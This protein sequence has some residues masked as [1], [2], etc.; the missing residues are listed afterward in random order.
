MFWFLSSNVTE[1]R[2]TT[3]FKI[4]IAF[5][6]DASSSM[7]G[8]IH[9]AQGQIWGLSESLQQ[10]HKRNRTVEVE[11]AVISYGNYYEN[12][13]DFAILHSGFSSQIDSLAEALL[14]IETYGGE[15][16]CGAVIQYALDVLK[17]SD[18]KE[19]LKIIFIAGN[20]SFDQ[21]HVAYQQSIENAKGKDVVVNTLFCGAP[22]LP[23]YTIW[24][25]AS[26]LS[27]GESLTIEMDSII[28]Y[29]ETFWDDKIIGLNNRLNETLVPQKT[30][31]DTSFKKMLRLDEMTLWLGKYVMCKRIAQKANRSMNEPAW[32]LVNQY[33]S[34]PS[35][36][37]RSDSTYWP[38]NLWRMTSAQRIIFL[39]KK[40][41]QRRTYAE[42]IAIYLAKADE[43]RVI[44]HGAVAME[45]NF[46][47]AVLTCIQ[48]QGKRENFLFPEEK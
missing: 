31:G 34:D 48:Q 14:E 24:H 17:W 29:S 20:E 8:L 1:A 10:V 45:Q 44:V 15:E 3:A 47:K 40:M 4:Q 41:A 21:C 25:E 39:Q 46:D 42:S 26:V 32:D 38:E 22:G 9:Q 33:Q 7:D 43:Q 11:Y 19:D 5:L 12:P 28:K 36:V 6:L 27:K 30:T 16:C 37:E 23:D 18:Q 13:L 2:D 35:I